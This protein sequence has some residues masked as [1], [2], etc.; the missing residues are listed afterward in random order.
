MSLTA[1]E[2]AE[3][4]GMSR[5]GIMKAIHQGKLSAQKDLN[6]QWQ[7]EPVEL[8]R[9]YEPVSSTQPEATSFHEE[10]PVAATSYQVEIRLLRELLATKDDT[11]DD[12]RQ[13]L[14]AEA[15][16]R[17]KLTLMLTTTQSEKPRS[18]WARLLGG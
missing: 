1:K 12:L 10:T 8:F 13:R 7:I 3:Q 5:Q 17:R 6:G 9:V 18:W 11:I 2:A 4:V 15:D 14:D 16:E